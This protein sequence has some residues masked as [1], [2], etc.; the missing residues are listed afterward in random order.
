MKG[1]IKLN[2]TK[3]FLSVWTMYLIQRKDGTKRPPHPLFLR[4]RPRTPSKSSVCLSSP[5]VTQVT[6]GQ[7]TVQRA[8]MLN[9]TT[10]GPTVLQFKCL[11]C[12]DRKARKNP[13]RKTHRKATKYKW[14]QFS[15]SARIALWQVIFSWRL[16]P[17]INSLISTLAAPRKRSQWS[18]EMNQISH[19]LPH[20]CAT[21]RAS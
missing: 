1:I 19:A 11:Q 14:Q 13:Q 12:E 21:E 3:L 9:N 6:A 18:P 4:S 17:E 16:Y 5:M 15:K 2:S 20:P 7:A 8:L 10:A